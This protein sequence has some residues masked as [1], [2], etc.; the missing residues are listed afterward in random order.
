MHRLF[1]VP[2]L[3]ALPRLQDG[4]HIRAL[5]ETAT[6]VNVDTPVRERDDD[7]AAD[8]PLGVFDLRD[9][10]VG[11]SILTATPPAPG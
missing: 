11:Q 8:V 5:A 10:Q 2:V 4:P 9:A 6:I 3:P 1:S 7:F